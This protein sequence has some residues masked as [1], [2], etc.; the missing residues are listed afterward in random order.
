MPLE[1]I[2]LL[3]KAKKK[4]FKEVRE[5][6]KDIRPEDE[7]RMLVFARRIVP[8]RWNIFTD[9]K[10]YRPEKGPLNIHLMIWDYDE[11]VHIAGEVE[12]VWHF[13]P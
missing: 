12:K 13:I 4:Y 5:R 10:D 7:K 9:M 8:K 2:K 3:L 1:E 6:Y 11:N